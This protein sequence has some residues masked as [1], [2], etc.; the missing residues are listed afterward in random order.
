MSG[1]E[2]DDL[3]ALRAASWALKELK[4]AFTQSE[5]QVNN[6]PD[7]NGKH[8]KQPIDYDKICDLVSIDV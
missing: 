6:G 3:K 2:D 7:E 5:W 1:S 4:S 8:A